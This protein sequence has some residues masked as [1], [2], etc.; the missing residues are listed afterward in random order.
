[1]D[2]V[3][4]RY[5]RQEFAELLTCASHFLL[6]VVTTQ[7]QTKIPVRVRYITGHD[8]TPTPVTEVPQ[9][10]LKTAQDIADL[11]VHEDGRFSVRT[12]LRF[13]GVADEITVLQFSYV[14]SEWKDTVNTSPD[15]MPYEPIHIAGPERDRRTHELLPLRR[16]LIVD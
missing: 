6:G 8:P 4:K 14:P 3:K 9:N 11:A 15:W 7:S 1:M 13:L 2:I 5:S 12:H 10:A 16:I